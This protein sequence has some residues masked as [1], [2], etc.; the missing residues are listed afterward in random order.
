MGEKR[1]VY[2]Q[3]RVGDVLSRPIINESN[4]VILCKK[5]KVLTEEI[6]EWLDKFRHSDIYILE[7]EWNKVWHLEE[8]H[9]KVYSQSKSHVRLFLEHFRFSDDLEHHLISDTCEQFFEA[10]GGDHSAVMGCVNKVRS[11]DE[12]TYTHCLNVGMLAVVLGK[13][14]GLSE[15]ALREL[16]VAGM[17]H[18]VGKYRVPEKILN[19]KGKLTEAEYFVMKK[20]V[21]YGYEMLKNQPQIKEAIKLG[22]LCHHERNDGTGYP[23]QLKGEEIHLYGKILAVVDVYDAMISERVYKKRETPFEV[24]EYMMNYELG[25]LDPKIL[26]TFIKNIAN[27]YIGVDVVLNTRQNAKVVFLPQHCMYRPIVK[28]SSEY[29][30][31]S[32]QSHIKIIDIV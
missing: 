7:N 22:V 15:E 25:N 30:D 5:G 17:L 32:Q 14:M 13:W 12:Y 27:Y 11:V 28:T 18:D 26:L 2:H 31:L 29:I 21:N 8:K 23:R 19:K 16:M 6:I 9:E 3:C 10:F 1:V 4:G 24:M 20:H